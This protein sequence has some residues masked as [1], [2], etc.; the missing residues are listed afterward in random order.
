[1][2]AE[3]GS[4]TG[5]WALCVALSVAATLVALMSARLAHRGR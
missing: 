1:V 3:H 2:F 4:Y 5:A